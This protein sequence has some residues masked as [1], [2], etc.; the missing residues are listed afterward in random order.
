MLTLS[1]YVLNQEQGLRGQS[2]DASTK[3]DIYP[4]ALKGASDALIKQ[5]KLVQSDYDFAPW[6]YASW[7]VVGIGGRGL[8]ATEYYMKL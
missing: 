3:V 4:F 1:S 7:Q 5:F 6:Y 8:L 2:K